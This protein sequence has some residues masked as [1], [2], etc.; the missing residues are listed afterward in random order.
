[1]LYGARHPLLVELLGERVVPVD[2]QVGDGRTIV[3]ITGPNTGGKT[4]A[5]KTLGLVTL[6][7][8]AGLFGR[9]SGR[10]FYDY[11]DPKKPVPMKLG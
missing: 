2:L 11:S 9:K 7:V 8:Q 1:M 4:V 5:L 10:G 6:M 3:V